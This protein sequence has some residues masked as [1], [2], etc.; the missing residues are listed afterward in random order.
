MCLCSVRAE[1]RGSDLDEPDDDD[2]GAAAV[3]HGHGRNLR[4]AAGKRVPPCGMSARVQRS[5]GP[6]LL[7]GKVRSDG[8]DR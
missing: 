6:P 3:D 8:S 2:A 5:P 4:L 1:R 7:P